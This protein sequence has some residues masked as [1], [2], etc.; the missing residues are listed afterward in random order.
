LTAH[1]SWQAFLA[2]VEPHIR[3]H[4]EPE[5]IVSGVETHLRR[6]L[7][8]PDWLEARYR[9]AI[10]AKPYAQYL[11]YRP[12]DHAF[13]VVSFVWNAGQ[14]SPVHDHCTW[15]VIGQLEGEEEESRFRLTAAG[16]ELIGVHRARRGDVAHVYPPA[17]DIHQIHNRTA[18]PTISIHIYGGDIGSQRRHVYDPATGRKQPFVSGYDEADLTAEMPG[19]AED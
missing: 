16:L 1:A 8:G 6:L 10:P 13:S 18:S 17:R 19:S 15:G 9:R 3:S 14:G 7:A 11:L 12:S 5:K 4:A 2:A